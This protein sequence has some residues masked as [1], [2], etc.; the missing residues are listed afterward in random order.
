MSV[1]L[2]AKET[3]PEAVREEFIS[4]RRFNAWVFKWLIILALVPTL[5]P[6]AA[7]LILSLP[8]PHLLLVLAVLGLFWPPSRKWMWGT[9][10]G[11]I[12]GF[13]RLA[14]RI[15][16]YA[17]VRLFSF[18]KSLI[19]APDQPEG[20]FM[21]WYRRWRWLDRQGKG[22]LIDGKRARLPLPAT[23]QG[24]ILQGGMGMGKSSRFIMPNLLLLPK[25][26]PSFVI[27]DTSGELY[28][29]TSGYLASQGYAIRAFNLLDPT[30]SHTYNPLMACQSQQDVAE[31]AQVLVQSS[32]GLNGSFGGS[33]PFWTQAAEKL[34]RIL[35]QCLLNQGDDQYKTL[36]N[37]RHLILN[38]D[39]HQMGQ[40]NGTQA[41]QTSNPSGQLGKITPFVLSATQNDPQTFQA[42]KSMVNGNYKTLQSILMSA[43]VALDPLA[44]PEIGQLTAGGSL[45][46]SE[47]RQRPTALYLMVNQTQIPLYRFLLN[48]IYNQIFSALLTNADNP[49][50]PVWM[51]LDEFGHFR[52]KNFEIIATTARK[53]KVTL[54]LALQSAVQLDQQYGRDGAKIIRDGLG[55]ALYLPGLSFEDARA[56]SGRLGTHNKAPLMT[57]D[58]I[59]R[60]ETGQAL[61]I[62]TNQD[63]IR[64]QARGYFESRVLR[65]RAALPPASLPALPQG[66]APLLPL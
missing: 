29:Q 43:D 50:R 34:I 31:L 36:A 63:P 15:L 53:Y 18:A 52:V 4:M 60:M 40:A 49:G 58:Q 42:Y 10:R 3:S 64:L 65:Q 59:I 47:L 32:L 6:V 23:Y 21:S 38:F 26:K 11:L 14:W 62:P 45:D 1:K 57:A 22:Y 30:H 9:L 41:G 13:L 5:V 39:A 46:F 54:H 2:K 48:L 56:I 24:S 61:A 37:V 35:A 25:D 27:S 51:L 44:A 12:L 8:V 17:L 7:Q 33:D 16:R 19:F 55:T 28:K 66:H 20:R